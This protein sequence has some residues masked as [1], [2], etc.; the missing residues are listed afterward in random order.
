MEKISLY[1]EMGDTPKK[2]AFRSFLT[3]RGKPAPVFY[4]VLLLCSALISFTVAYSGVG[5]GIAVLA[6]IVG[7]PLSYGIVVY[8][9]FG[10]TILLISA[11]LLMWVYRMGIVDYPLGTL[12]DALL[13]LLIVGF[14]IK[15]KKNPDWTMFK[16]P[17][18]III[19]LW[20]SYNILQFA[21]P[22]AESRMAWIYTIRSVAFVMLMYFIFCYHIRTVAFIRFIVKI[23]IA[24]SLF[25]ALYGLKQ[26]FIGFFDY[27]FRSIDNQRFRSLLFIAGHWRKFS[28]F[29]DPVAFSYNMVA[30]AIMC[31][32][33]IFRPAMVLWKRITLFVLAS[34]F[35][36]S[37]LFSGTR[38]AYVLI[39]A[40]IVL[41]VILNPARKVLLICSVI[42]VLFTIVVFLPTS[43]PTIRRFQTAFRP[44]EDASFNAR[45][46]NQKRFQPY[47]RS[48]PIG[49][50]LGATG[51]WGVKFAPH[52]YL[53]QLPP[54]SG[55]VRVAAELGWIGLF[56]IC[57]LFFIILKTG[58][59]SYWKIKDPELKN[60]TL[61]MILI[62]FAYAI[63]NYPQEAIVQFPSNVYFY[64]YTALIFVVARL[65]AEKSN[66]VT[67]ENNI[68]A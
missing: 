33:L 7:L 22:F 60:Y 15:Q 20:I 47:I 23:W 21:N 52:S 4:L 58:I 25:A 9:K 14:L 61:A 66:K 32:V 51:G 59:D 67:N 1:K 37:M 13:G 40:A 54:D 39:P 11:Y 64:L 41:F 3:F 45:K 56:M 19:V 38:G 57:T 31:L 55:Y 36:Y 44:S 5:G 8:P 2:S 27:E 48:H 35:L 50:G 42:A 63:G 49:G 18:G 46:N 30:S 24:L 65:D 6:L 17:V 62:V 53:A 34:I 68:Q 26:E 16:T 12:M 10:I 28:I 43:S 29:T